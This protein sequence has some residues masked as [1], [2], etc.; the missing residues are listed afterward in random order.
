M[1]VL[2]DASLQHAAILVMLARLAHQPQ[3]G[4][5]DYYVIHHPAS[6]LL[7]PILQTCFVSALKR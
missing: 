3:K 7:K 1:P 2:G 6:P 4:R 5:I